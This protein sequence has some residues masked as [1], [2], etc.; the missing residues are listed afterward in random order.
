M[1]LVEQRWSQ[2]AL[3]LAL[4]CSSRHYAGRSFQV[5]AQEVEGS[6]IQGAASFCLKR[7]CEVTVCCYDTS[8]MIFIFL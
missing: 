3:Q 6:D 5:R 8:F 4:S 7:V 1:A 2:V